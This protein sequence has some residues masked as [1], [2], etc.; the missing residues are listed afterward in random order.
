MY[1]PKTAIPTG[2]IHVH[3]DGIHFRVLRHYK[4]NGKTIRHLTDFK[5]RWQSYLSEQTLKTDSQGRLRNDQ[6][7]IL[8]F[9]PMDKTAADTMR[10]D[11]NRL[12]GHSK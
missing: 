2:T 4:L 1:N 8:E 3:E 12:Y 11:L 5:I 9:I 6:G 7:H 10:P